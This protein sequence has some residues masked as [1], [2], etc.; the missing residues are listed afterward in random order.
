M[1]LIDAI[2]A[3][4]KG[5]TITY[6]QGDCYDEAVVLNKNTS[7]TI[8]FKNVQTFSMKDALLGKIIV[9]RGTV[10]V[11]NGKD[12]SFAVEPGGTL[13]MKKGKYGSLTNRGRTILKGAELKSM[14]NVAG[15]LECDNATVKG[16][17]YSKGGKTVIYKGKYNSS[18]S[19]RVLGGT[20]YLK[21][22]EYTDNTKDVI[23]V[24]KDGELI[25]SGGTFYGS[26]SN[27]GKMTLEGGMINGCVSNHTGELFIKGGVVTANLQVLSCGDKGVTNV[28]G[29]TFISKKDAPV[30]IGEV[31]QNGR[32]SISEAV[33]KTKPGYE[34]GAIWI[35][36]KNNQNI[37]I[38]K[39]NITYYG[40]K[41]LICE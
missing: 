1:K 28:I 6:L 8:D 32:V 20:V 31:K 27:C 21:G 39:A 13:I 37:Y 34:R 41:R 40:T 3:V 25:V 15:T 23:M 26:I 12:T 17:I 22:G 9:K 19:M 2:K 11:K 16:N 24:G 14:W 29:G 10:T 33:L 18:F 30:I 36:K 38:S 7:Y 35:P 5:Q 4:K